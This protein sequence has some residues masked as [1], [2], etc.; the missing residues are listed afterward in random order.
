MNVPK[1]F[2]PGDGND[3]GVPEQEAIGRR[4]CMKIGRRK[5]QLFEQLLGA[6]QIKTL[7]A[8]T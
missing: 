1:H 2:A 3:M 8:R 4:K 6:V 7:N 5:A